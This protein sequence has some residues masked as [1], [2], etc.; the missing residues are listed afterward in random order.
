MINNPRNSSLD[1]AIPFTWD[2][3]WDLL[4]E[5]SDEQSQGVIANLSG[6]LLISEPGAEGGYWRLCAFP[7]FFLGFCPACEPGK[8]G[9]THPSSSQ[10][11]QTCW[12]VGASPVN[13]P[14][15][16]DKPFCDIMVQVNAIPPLKCL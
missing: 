2:L 13:W 11:A 1:K 15:V 8:G 5:S 3:L 10:R 9:V 4:L 16:K 14:W 12:N 6:L 7:S